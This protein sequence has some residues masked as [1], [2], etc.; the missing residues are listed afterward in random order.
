MSVPSSVVR[1]LKRIAVAIAVIVAFV[2]ASSSVFAGCSCSCRTRYHR[3]VTDSPAIPLLSPGDTFDRYKIEALLGEGGMGQVYRVHDTRLHRNVALKFLRIDASAEHGSSPQ[4]V[5]AEAVH[6]LVREARAAAALDHPNA[7]S[8]YDVGEH[9]GI[10]YLAMELITGRSLRALIGDPEIPWTTRLKWLVD[11]ARAL[12]AAHAKGLVHRDI[13]PDNVMV[14]DDGVVKVLDFGIARRVR[15][16]SAIAANPFDTSGGLVT[17]TGKGNV[18]GTPCYM[19]PEQMRGEAMDGRAD[20]FAWGVVAYELLTG[21]LPWDTSGDTVKLVAQVLSMDPA[22]FAEHIEGLPAHVEA[23]VLK[24]MSKAPSQ[25]FASMDAIILALEPFLDHAALRT[26][27]RSFR[28]EPLRPLAVPT[29]TAISTKVAVSTTALPTPPPV[30]APRRLSRAALGAAGLAAL[31]AVWLGARALPHRETASPSPA[32]SASPTVVTVADLPM[33][34]TTVPGAREA[35]RLALESYRDA[36]VDGTWQNLTRAVELDPA[37]AAA[38]LRLAIVM[39]WGAEKTTEARAALQKAARFRS[40][41]SERDAALLDAIEPGILRDPPDHVE[42]GKRL[43][44]VAARYP[45]DPEL[46]LL[47]GS[48]LLD[49]GDVEAARRPLERTTELDPRWVVGWVALGQTRAYL[50]DFDGAM[51][52]WDRCSRIAPTVSACRG[53]RT[54]LLAQQGECAKIEQE[55]KSLMALDPSSPAGYGVLARALASEGR[56]RG[57]VEEALSQ[58]WSRIG[59]PAR[60]RVKAADEASVALLFGD[61][62]TARTKAEELDRIVRDEPSEADHAVPARLLVAIADELGDRVAAGKIATGYLSR[63]EAWTESPHLDENAIFGDP[64]PAM[65]AAATRAGAIDARESER[66]REAWVARWER[67]ASP[68]FK[69]YLWFAAYGDEVESRAEAEQALAALGPFSPLP[70]DHRGTMSVAA[71]GATYLM[72]GRVAEARPLVEAGAK[73]CRALEDPIAH[74]RAQ[75]SLGLV[76]EDGGDHDGACAA[77]GVVLDRWGDVKVSRTAAVARAHATAL[78]CAR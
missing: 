46:S 40:N 66:R 41:L 7:V 67:R 33:P 23:T 73:V 31:L 70:R 10:A 12:A 8:V 2:S 78:R 45:T 15:L 16:P 3:P 76:R 27:F 36:D 14:R 20:Q 53:N 57:A 42:L 63:R 71:L 24:A 51:G 30:A 25:R 5:T 60:P 35:Y 34:S 43:S 11:V 1:A 22:P 77:Y 38:H 29:V 52:A 47:Y 21:S 28:P 44:A 26:D 64:T 58:K 4:E 13:K 49:E 61:F 69:S 17:L 48:A 59:T 19:A 62:A 32:E 6:R 68:F 18:V 37:M 56:P 39:F 50:G 65:L 72:A 54:T 9:D 74:T 75:L 55:A